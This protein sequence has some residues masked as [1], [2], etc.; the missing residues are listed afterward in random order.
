MFAIPPIFK[1]VIGKIMICTNPDLIVHRGNI[2]ELCAG[3][4]AKTFETLGGKV[5]Y[6]GKP[7]NNIYE[8]C[9]KLIKGENKILVIALPLIESK[10]SNPQ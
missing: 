10:D 6:Y 3:S 1:N 2:E 4:V 5:I 9:Y 8:F 7:H